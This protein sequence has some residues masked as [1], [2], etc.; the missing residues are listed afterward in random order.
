[1]LELEFYPQTSMRLCKDTL[2]AILQTLFANENEYSAVAIAA[3]WA[4]GF[5]RKTIPNTLTTAA[6]MSCATFAFR[7]DHFCKGRSPQVF[8]WTRLTSPRNA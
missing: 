2:R 6:P 7:I 1:M 3:N 4:L 8:H 5:D